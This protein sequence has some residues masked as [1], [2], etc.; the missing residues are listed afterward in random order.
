[1]MS[2]L[3]GLLIRNSL[4]E[5]IILKQQPTVE[6]IFYET[7]QINTRKLS[8]IGWSLE[9]VKEEIDKAKQKSS[10]GNLQLNRRRMEP[11]S[12]PEL[13]ARPLGNEVADINNAVIMSA[14]WQIRQ[15]MDEKLFRVLQ[16]IFVEEK[17]QEK[18][19]PITDEKELLFNKFLDNIEKGI[20]I[21]HTLQNRMHEHG[22]LSSRF[23]LL[24]EDITKRGKR[25][26]HPRII[27]RLLTFENGKLIE[28]DLYE[29][30]MTTLEALVGSPRPDRDAIASELKNIMN[31]KT[32]TA[33]E[34]MQLLNANQYR[35]RG[36][37]SKEDF[38]TLRKKLDR[39]LEEDW[40]SALDLFYKRIDIKNDSGKIIEHKHHWGTQNLD[41]ELLGEWESLKR[42]TEL[43]F[44]EIRGKKYLKAIYELETQYYRLKQYFKA[45]KKLK[46]ILLEQQALELDVEYEINQREDQAHAHYKS[47]T[48]NIDDY[49][50]YRKMVQNDIKD[51]AKQHKDF[52]RRR[53][54]DSSYDPDKKDE[55]TIEDEADDI[56]S[57][58]RQMHEQ[59]KTPKIHGEKIDT[60]QKDDK[61]RPIYRYEGGP[62][63]IQEVMEQW[64]KLQEKLRRKKE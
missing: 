60:G 22:L 1:M 38:S 31:N 29:N 52:I 21:S 16:E 18:L 7:L 59:Q 6:E 63:N 57:Q 48:Q 30:S 50:K 40:D 26:L 49:A 56:L 62:E 45:Y 11:E 17:P 10:R 39:V 3:D 12:D 42:D 41:D 20:E 51:K 34:I 15:W 37:E 32:R 43:T 9:E 61:G 44:E 2:F 23:L 35:Y 8:S 53:K 33:T 25:L 4:D 54:K 36:A 55:F 28:T 5:D 13:T 14:L 58:I 64:K 19:R 27:D 24:L 46:E 47:V